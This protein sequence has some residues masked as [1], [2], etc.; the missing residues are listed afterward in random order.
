MVLTL[1]QVKPLS[2][3]KLTN[4]VIDEFRKSPLLDMM[5]F[6]N[7]AKAQGGRSF[8]Y[9]YNR[10]KTLPL[11]A[12][13]ELNAEYSRQEA[14]T[15]AVTVDLKIFGGKFAIDRA[16]QAN[17][18]QV[19]DLFN[20]QMLQKT[21]AARALFN[22]YCIIGD[23]SVTGG[24]F[25]GL[26][27]IVSGT[28]TDYVPSATIDISTASAIDTNATQLSFAVRQ[29]I[30]K[31]DST[32]DF[33]IV[34]RELYACLQS[35]ADK[36]TGFNVTKT[37][38]ADG[39]GQEI[40]TWG[41]MRILE[42]GDKMGTSDPII[43]IDNGTGETSAYFVRMGLDGFHGITPEGNTL[44]KTYFPDMTAPGAV[45]EGEVEFVGAVAVKATR[46][47]G[48]ISGIKVI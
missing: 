48:K 44:I 27:K 18:W 33:M 28:S 45:K 23:K 41:G 31:M 13:R 3:D 36:L 9:S 35:V 5:T 22:Q 12:Q 1:A 40:L 39:I 30:S 19:V 7:N 34:N 6:D 11:A 38:T 46:A 29:A 20:F 14:D 24:G 15:E 16:L 32:P 25:D 43:P 17:E 47:A 21:Q 37:A 26:D 10:M 2:Q 42:M 8:T 4:D